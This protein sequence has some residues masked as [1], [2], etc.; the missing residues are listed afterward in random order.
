MISKL[1]IVDD[2]NLNTLVAYAYRM[3]KSIFEEIKYPLAYFIYY[4]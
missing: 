2:K 4:M 1:F 3:D